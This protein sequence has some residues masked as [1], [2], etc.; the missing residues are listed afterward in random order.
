MEKIGSDIQRLQIRRRINF[1]FYSLVLGT[2][3]SFSAFVSLHTLQ[4]S[5]NIQGKLGSLGLTVVYFG[6]VVYSL[7]VAPITMK[8]FGLGLN[9]VISDLSYLIYCASNYY[10]G[11]YVLL[12]ASIIS[13]VAQSLLLPATSIAAFQLAE[14][15]YQCSSQTEEV[16]INRFQSRFVGLFSSVSIVGNIISFAALSG[17]K[18]GSIED[19]NSNITFSSVN[20]IEATTPSLSP[21]RSGYNHCGVQDCQDPEIIEN[22]INQ[23]VPP[24]KIST[25]ILVSAACAVSLVSLIIHACVYPGIGKFGRKLHNLD[26]EITQFLKPNDESKSMEFT[27]EDSCNNIVTAAAMT[28]TEKV[29]E[30]QICSSINKQ[31]Y[32]GQDISTL[33]TD[34]GDLNE[35]VGDGYWETLKATA[36]FFIRP[37]SILIGFTPFRN[38]MIIGFMFS[39]VTRAYASCVGGVEMVGLIAMAFGSVGILVGLIYGHVV[40]YTGRNVI[41]LIGFL[42]EMSVYIGCYVWVPDP[43]TMYYVFLM[44][45]GHGTVNSLLYISVNGE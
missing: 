3:L 23:Y 27:L 28:T 35:N 42:L 38:G 2:V 18:S 4:T 26:R 1:Y 37:Q 17:S 36:K 44:F 7:F 32:A 30:S 9:L 34:T 5:I 24:D 25:Y 8:R 29:A 12:P 39:D 40:K 45:I 13:S 16:Y 6:S 11:I 21:N 19:E 41:M 22:N 15:F 33:N 31:P 43:N 20:T 14:R 10:P